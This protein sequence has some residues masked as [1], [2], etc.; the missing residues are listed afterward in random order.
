MKPLPGPC[1]ENG[2]YMIVPGPGF[3][4]FG[5]PLIG[6]GCTTTGSYTIGIHGVGD[7]TAGGSPLCPDAL[8]VFTGADGRGLRYSCQRWDPSTDVFVSNLQT[9]LSV[10]GL[11]EVEGQVQAC[12]SWVHPGPRLDRSILDHVT[13]P[14]RTLPAN[15]LR[16]RQ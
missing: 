4:G 13:T 7:S 6:G 9:F 12:G 5:A 1:A 11:V 16:A 8:P 10:T 15:V 2:L 3:Q 14:V